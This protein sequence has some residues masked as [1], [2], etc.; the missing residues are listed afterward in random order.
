MHQLRG[1]RICLPF[2]LAALLCASPT[3]V[4]AQSDDLLKSYQH[5]ESARLKHKVA[6]ALKAGN[7]AVRLTEQSGDKQQLGEL[8]RDLGDY[9]AQEG[10]DAEALAYFE[11]ALALQQDQ[12]GAVDPDLVPLLTLMANLQL[13]GQHY[14]EAET[15]LNRILGLERA[16]YGDHHPNTLATLGRLRDLY[17]ATHDTEAVARVEAQMRPPV[18]TV[19]ALPGP[20]GRRYQEKNGFATVRV[21]Y[22]TNRAATGSPKAKAVLE[23]WAASRDL[24]RVITPKDL[25]V[26]RQSSLKMG[27]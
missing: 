20:G 9:A 5:F 26:R 17:L 16:A 27:A 4:N 1:L 2:L 24:F 12:L 23:S 8:L 7:D 3:L 15:L 18:A 19:R 21:F 13:K 6:D 25:L 11:R 10:K 14:G 22:G